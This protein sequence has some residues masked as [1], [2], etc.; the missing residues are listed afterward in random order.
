MPHWVCGCNQVDGRTW[1]GA[2]CATHQPPPQG[3][4]QLNPGPSGSGSERGPARTTGNPGIGQTAFQMGVHRRWCGAA[5][6]TAPKNGYWQTGPPLP[7]A[8]TATVIEVEG[9]LFPQ[10]IPLSLYAFCA[11]QHAIDSG[12]KIPDDEQALLELAFNLFILM[13]QLRT[14]SDDPALVT[15]LEACQ[16]YAYF[17]S[18]LG[19]VEIARGDKLEKVYFHIPNICM[20]LTRDLKEDILYLI[21]RS[22]PI[23]KVSL[24]FT[25]LTAILACLPSKNTLEKRPVVRKTPLPSP[26][27]CQSQKSEL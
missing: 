16:G 23:A 6:N 3:S 1:R 8:V 19:V 15:A 22:S 21:D 17:R 13:F 18:L 12:S 7:C 5:Q 24:P 2:W 11:M 27:P 20:Y 25:F 4:T 10:L 9:A 26:T 14:F